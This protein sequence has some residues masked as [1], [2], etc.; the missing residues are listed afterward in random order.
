[1]AC[2]KCSFYKPK[3]LVEVKLLES[4]TNLQRMLQEISLTEEERFAIED[5]IEAFEQLCERL[6]DVPT[7]AGLT[8]RQISSTSSEDIA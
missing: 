4:K 3:N 6:A 1:M 5:G 7:P 2:T 8:P